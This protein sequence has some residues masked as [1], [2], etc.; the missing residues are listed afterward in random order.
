MNQD[1]QDLLDRVRVSI[2]SGF[3]TPQDV[4]ELIDD[5]LDGDADEAAVRASIQP[6]FVRKAA[7]EATWPEVT[8]CDRLDTAFRQLDGLG[9]VALQNAR[10]TM[11]DGHSDV[12]EALAQAGPGR[13]HGY[14]FYHGQDVERAVEGGGVWIAFGSLTDDR[15]ADV[16][17]GQTVQR[18]LAAAGLEVRWAGTLDRRIEL[19]SFD[20]KRRHTPHA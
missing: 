15:D 10:Y 18:E 1:T 13:Y 4:H 14:A 6:E 16:E 9:I 11:S 20:W 12:S 8:D 19:A 17:I 5:L 3:D 2:W 7:A